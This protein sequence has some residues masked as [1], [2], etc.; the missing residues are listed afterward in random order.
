MKANISKYKKTLTTT[1]VAN[2][3]GL[4]LVCV[5]Y[6]ALMGHRGYSFVFNMLKGNYETISTYKN[7]SL[8][9]RY[10]MKLGSSYQIFKFIASQTPPDA[11][12]YL[13]GVE[14]F[15]D[16]SNGVEFKNGTHR[17]GWIV[18]FLHPRTVVLESEYDKSTYS[19]DI[20]HV[21]IINGVGAE[22]LPY[23]LEEMQPFCVV[24]IK[25]PKKVNNSSSA[26][27]K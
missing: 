19:K 24:P 12:I 10:I 21:A 11:V 2:I 27:I 15:N 25:L 8:D 16:K 7:A 3:I 13:P 22:I 18:R 9:D 1:I 4:L 5:L 26:N 14:A 6:S 17:K 23:K 20:T